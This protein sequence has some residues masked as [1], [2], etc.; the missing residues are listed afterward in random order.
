[1]SKEE[2]DI[3]PGVE[4]KWG[5]EE[6]IMMLAISPQK[7]DMVIRKGDSKLMIMIKKEGVWHIVTFLGTENPEDMNKI[8]NLEGESDEPK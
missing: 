7:E 6:S 3:K 4:T 2:L 1:M 8:L 5:E